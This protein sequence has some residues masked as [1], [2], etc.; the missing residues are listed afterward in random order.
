MFK[1]SE[2]PSGAGG[3]PGV[4]RPHL[5]CGLSQPACHGYES[6]KMCFHRIRGLPQSS[7]HNT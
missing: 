3:N 5:S 2:T 4:I 6:P 1:S 7:E